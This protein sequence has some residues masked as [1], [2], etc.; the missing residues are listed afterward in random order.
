MRVFLKSRNAFL[1]TAG[2]MWGVGGWPAKP[3]SW[4]NVCFLE[5]INGRHPCFVLNRISEITEVFL[6]IFSLVVDR[7]RKE[8]IVCQGNKVMNLAKVLG[9]TWG[10]EFLMLHE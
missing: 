5:N 7:K 1:H 2:F 9:R 3:Q 10:K 8:N 6:F 4:K